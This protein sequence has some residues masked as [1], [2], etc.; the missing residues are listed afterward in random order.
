MKTML[1][2]MNRYKILLRKI[3]STQLCSVLLFIV[4]LMGFGACTKA[5]Y[6]LGSSFM[7]SDQQVATG[8]FSVGVGEQI[9]ET[10]LYEPRLSDFNAANQVNGYFGAE[11]NATFGKRRTGFFTQYTP[12]VE[13]ALSEELFG[14]EPIVDSVLLYLTPTEFSGDSTQMVEF[15]V[16]E[17]LNDDFL[18]SKADSVFS[19]SSTLPEGATLSATPV[20]TF[21]YPNQD[22]E[23]YTNSID[24]RMNIE[25]AG[26]EFLKRLMLVGDE[27]NYE[28][29][30]WEYASWVKQFKGLYI[31]PAETQNAS[32]GGTYSTNLEGSGFGFYARN[33]VPGIEGYIKDTVGMSYSF[34]DVNAVYALEN[35]AG[36]VSINT[37]D[38]KYPSTIEDGKQTSEI[39]VEGMGGVVTTLCFNQAFFEKMD[40]TLDNEGVQYDDVFFNTAII[41]LYLLTAQN[42]EPLVYNSNTLDELNGMATSLGF[43]STYSS[44]LDSEGYTSLAPIL[45]YMSQYD[46]D[47]NTTHNLG[48]YLNRNLGCYEMY[49]A[50]QMVVIWNDYQDAKAQAGGDISKIDWENSEWNRII[51]APVMEN[52]FTLR[53]TEL[54]GVDNN[55]GNLAPVRM[56]ATYTLLKNKSER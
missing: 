7:P 48:G 34:R 42:Y 12:L 56:D 54:Q 9:I 33:K 52:L 18:T 27:E 50:N 55:G 28:I 53:Y 22:K 3:N 26:E 44:V 19:I 2:F 49:V 20:F 23:V 46:M 16:Y 39:L 40:A 25:T 5:D 47:G 6:E 8:S 35:A 24:V 14:L 41:R 30:N 11:D 10:R 43:Y 21:T 15:E 1:N 37:V 13:Y 36:G 38:R 45:D 4:V 32:V 31:V 17:V 29:Y 51:V